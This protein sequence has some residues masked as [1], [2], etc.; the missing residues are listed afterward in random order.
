MGSTLSQNIQSLCWSSV[1]KLRVLV[2]KKQKNYIYPFTM[3]ICVHRR[4]HRVSGLRLLDLARQTTRKPN[5]H[6]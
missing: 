2:G 6:V 5:P 1:L 3:N 4:H